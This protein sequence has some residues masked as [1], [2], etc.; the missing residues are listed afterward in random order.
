[1]Q[2][3]YISE[4]EPR[5]SIDEDEKSIFQYLNDGNCESIEVCTTDQH[6]SMCSHMNSSGYDTESYIYHVTG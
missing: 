3:I 1:M 5:V 6:D 4:F 2:E